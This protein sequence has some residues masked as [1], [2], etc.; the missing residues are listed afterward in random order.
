VK[1]REFQTI[2]SRKFVRCSAFA[3][4]M[5]QVC[6][7]QKLGCGVK[8]DALHCRIVGESEFGGL[9]THVDCLLYCCVSVTTHGLVITNRRKEAPCPP[10]GLR[11]EKP[12]LHVY[13]T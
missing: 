1:S 3:R 9:G 2:S 4:E 7:D 8:W 13:I 12:L 10:L 5:S 11:R 6:G